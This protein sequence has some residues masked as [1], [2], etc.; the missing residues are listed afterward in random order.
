MKV[1]IRHN[2][3]IVAKTNL[4]VIPT[5]G[6]NIRLRNGQEFEIIKITFVESQDISE[7]DY[8]GYLELEVK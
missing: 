1:V 8:V 5:V 2:N 7:I 3:E 4:P 6:N